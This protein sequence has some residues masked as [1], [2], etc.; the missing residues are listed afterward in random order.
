MGFK[1]SSNSSFKFRISQ[2]FNFN[3]GNAK[4]KYTM[5]KTFP[6]PQDNA[7]YEKLV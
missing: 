6:S 5:N 3:E 7:V 1:K 2:Q 4:K